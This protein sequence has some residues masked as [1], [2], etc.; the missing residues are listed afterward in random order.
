MAPV[1]SGK[2]GVLV[3]HLGKAERK[4]D[5]VLAEAVNPDHRQAYSQVMQKL[6]EI[7]AILEA[8]GH[9]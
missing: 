1:F 8:V 7:A 9:G 5:Q 6:H 3:E 4:C 2:H